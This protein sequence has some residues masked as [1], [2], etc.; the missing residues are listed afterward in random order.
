MMSD[1]PMERNTNQNFLNNANGDVLIFGLGIGLIVFPLLQDE[2]IKSITVIELYQDLIDLV[3]PIIKQHDIHNK[4]TIKQGNLYETTLTKD[5]VFDCIYFDIWIDID[6]DHYEEQKALCRKFR[7]N[8]NKNNPNKFIDCWMKYYY[9]N[10]KR[11]ETREK[12]KYYGYC[13]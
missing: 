12:K 3:E 6:T 4:V 11:K 10:E 1:T 13:Y 9:L 8:L 5:E 2:N 7:K